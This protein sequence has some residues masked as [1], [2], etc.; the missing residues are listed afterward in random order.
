MRVATDHRDCDISCSGKSAQQDQRQGEVVIAIWREE[1][2]R[3]EL[4]ETANN[5]PETRE[6]HKSGGPQT[7]WLHSIRFPVDSGRKPFCGLDA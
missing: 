5:E 7:E 4:L 6:G 3:G 2:L 1:L